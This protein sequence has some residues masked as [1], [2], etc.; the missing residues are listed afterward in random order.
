MLCGGFKYFVCM[1]YRIEEHNLIISYPSFEYVVVLYFIRTFTI[2]STRFSKISAQT[3]KTNMI[4]PRRG[5]VL[6]G[7]CHISGFIKLL[8]SYF[9]VIQIQ[10]TFI[11]IYLTALFRHDKKQQHWLKSGKVW[12][13]ERRVTYFAMEALINGYREHEGHSTPL[14]SSEQNL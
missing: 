2:F 13:E 8:K 3:R 9:F 12:Y 11:F 4:W 14:L 5:A 6:H 1:F 7:I 10:A